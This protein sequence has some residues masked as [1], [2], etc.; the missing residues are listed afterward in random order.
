VDNALAAL[1][2]GSGSYIFSAQCPP[3]S[4][5]VGGSYGQF[6]WEVCFT[7][8]VSRWSAADDRRRLYGGDYG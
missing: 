7:P 4:I 2:P 1:A 8:G 5:G 3:S 6:S